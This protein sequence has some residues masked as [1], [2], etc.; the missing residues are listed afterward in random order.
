MDLNALITKYSRSGPRYTSYPTAPQWSDKHGADTYRRHLEALSQNTSKP[1][2]LYIHVPFCESLCY[3]C[4]CNILITKDHSRSREYVEH[5]LIELEAV[6]TALKARR[7]LGQISW[8]GGTPTYLTVGQMKQLH[9]GTQHLFEIAADAEVNIEVDPRVTTNEQLEW[10]ASLGF[11]RVSLGVQDFDPKVQETIHRIQPEE[12]TDSMVKKCRTLGMKGINLDLIYGL[13]YQT[14]TSFERTMDAVARIRPDRI[15]L[16]NYAHLPN[17]IAH[18]KI[19]DSH[20]MPSADE[21][22]AIFQLAY[23]RLIGAGYRS[24]GMDHFALREDELSR[25]LDKG[26]LYR[27]F[28][29]YS[30]QKAA[31]MIG[32]GC[33]AIGEVEGGYFQNVREVKPYQE[34][35]GAGGL[36]TLRGCVLSDDDKRR[37]W[38]IQTLMCQ[39]ELRS[40]RY[41]AMFGA[42]FETHFGAECAEL[43]GFFEEG[44]LERRGETLK[45]SDLGRLFV[46]NIAMVFDAYLKAP[47]PVRYSTTV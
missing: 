34:K 5:C 24:I 32:I 14:V 27:N 12:M 25:A 46:R 6:A 28:Q 13:P 11:N 20:P 41:E 22:V 3:Y 9:Q 4:G 21:R 43:T 44:L 15:A 31:D 40:D 23:E 2:S 36:A 30:V 45:V 38:V 29:G 17:M 47:S 39:F 16:Y 18:Q 10:L 8:G 19:L 26:S 35:I 7:K 33:S 42:P 37:K 1:L